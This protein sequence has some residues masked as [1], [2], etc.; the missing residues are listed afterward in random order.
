MGEKDTRTVQEDL[1]E[2]Y[3]AGVIE[4]RL[5]NDGEMV[6]R[7]RKNVPDFKAKLAKLGIPESVLLRTP[8]AAP[9]SDDGE[10]W[11]SIEEGQ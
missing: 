1:D 6:Y 7:L 9:K 10:I 2:L 3:D 8:K 4:K 5:R 11:H